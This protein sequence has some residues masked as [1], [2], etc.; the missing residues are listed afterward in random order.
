MLIWLDESHAIE[1][2]EDTMDILVTLVKAASSGIGSD[3]ASASIVP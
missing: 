1:D 2:L 3:V